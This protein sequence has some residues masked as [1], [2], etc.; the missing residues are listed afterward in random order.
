MG[1]GGI[2]LTPGQLNHAVAVA[3]DTAEETVVQYD[4]NLVTAGLR[5]KGGVGRSAPHVTV[6]DAA[7]L[8]TATLG[9]SRRKD[10]VDTV[11]AF[12]ESLYRPSKLT[13]MLV[14]MFHKAGEPL[15]TGLLDDADPTIKSLP[16]DHNFIQALAAL[17]EEASAPV[18]SKQPEKFLR[19]FGELVIIC[20]SPYA[21]GSIGPSGT[22]AQYRVERQERLAL[23]NEAAG[24]EYG[25]TQIRS[26]RGIA[27]ALMGLAFR[28]NGLPFKTTQEAIAQLSKAR[29]GKT[30]KHKTKKAF[31]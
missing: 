26:I 5:T 10:S 22:L 16:N 2:P 29:A 7:R 25:I 31:G 28:E 6:L 3:T 11:R 19:R 30:K 20:R 17:I 12:E 4:R 27:I 18:W 15:P 1:D 23:E 14:D 24:S 9:S 8:F 21:R 13:P